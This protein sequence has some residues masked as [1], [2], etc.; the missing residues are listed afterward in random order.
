MDWVE[1]KIHKA[2]T[3]GKNLCTI[4]TEDYKF[5]IAVKEEYEKLGYNVN[6]SVY[7][8]K[9]ADVCLITIAW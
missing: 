7:G 8:D 5:S 4:I 6:V 2:K 3:Q 9:D 1:E